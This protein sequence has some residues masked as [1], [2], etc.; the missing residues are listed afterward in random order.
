MSRLICVVTSTRADYGLLRWVMDG[1]AQHPDLE[2]QIIATG[3]HLSQT[4]GLSVTEIED[5]GFNIDCKVPCLNDSDTDQ[6]IVEATATAMTDIGK[7]LTHLNPD[8]VAVLGDRFEIF[9]AATA[10][11]IL[12]IPLAHLHG[13]ELTEGA[14]D[15]AFRHSITKMARYHF[16][17]AETYRS[18]VIQLGEQP[19]S[20]VCV[21]GLGVD[22]LKRTELLDRAQLE[23][24]L[25][26]KF[27]TRNLLIT[28]HPATLDSGSPGA[29]MSALLAALD[30]LDNVGLIFTFPNADSGGR[31]LIEQINDYVAS[32][33]LAAAYPSLGYRRYLSAVAQVDAVIGN[34]SS[35]LLEV[36]SLGKPA[37]NIGSRQQ[38]RLK[39]SSVCDCGTEQADI[40]AGLDQVLSESF[41]TGAQRTCNP[42]GD[43]GASDLI[44][45]ALATL[46]LDKG[47]LK[48][49]HDLAHDH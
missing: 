16:V 1:I 36:P 44:V 23:E 30:T 24:S 43:G 2:L 3:S 19:D 5:D 46:V 15:D 10:A 37:L 29:Q 34:S 26:F 11:M 33:P 20:V 22:T 27:Q 9:A 28:F 48:R 17:A 39:A 42:Y 7:A 6:A 32:R 40:S 25:N 18:R 8:I 47:N 45:N 13:G 12:G 38:G 41:R 14:L 21:G 35:G 4:H 31:H 49:F